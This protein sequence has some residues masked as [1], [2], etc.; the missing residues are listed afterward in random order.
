MKKLL[1]KIS[2]IIDIQEI[3][4]DQVGDDFFFKKIILNHGYCGIIKYLPEYDISGSIFCE[5]DIK[6]KDNINY[7][8]IIPILSHNINNY[9]DITIETDHCFDYILNLCKITA[10]DYKLKDYYVLDNMK[11]YTLTIFNESIFNNI[12]NILVSNNIAIK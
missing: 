4:Y 5:I 12:M 8:N 10:D 3:K 1:N 9:F 2:H 6:Y 11:K 7:N